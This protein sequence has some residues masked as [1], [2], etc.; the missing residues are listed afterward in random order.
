[1]YQYKIN[2]IIKVID[3][4]TIDV[5][6][7]LGFSISVRKR[8]RL[9]NINAPES[10]TRNKE[11]KAKGLKSK[12]F[13]KELLANTE[14]DIHLISYDIGKYG[15]VVGEVIVDGVSVGRTMVA[16]GHAVE[17]SY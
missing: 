3:G 11:E 4:D 5:D 9:F 2:K 17:K 16:E 8:V 12:K 7:D 15:R 10:R 13:L 1:M 6:I 14:E